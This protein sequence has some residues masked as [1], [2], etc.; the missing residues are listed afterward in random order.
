ML[1]LLPV[2]DEVIR[3]MVTIV[4][5]CVRATNCAGRYGGGEFA[6][7]LT[8]MDTAAAFPVAQ[9]IREQ[10]ETKRFRDLPDLRFTSSIGIAAADRSHTRLRDW[11]DAADVALY[12][13]KN[14]G[15]NRVVGETAQLA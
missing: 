2:D 7:I 10:A 13:A 5:D 15:R 4:R 1:T 11:M 9:R 14:A 6:I 3:A 12:Q 8:G